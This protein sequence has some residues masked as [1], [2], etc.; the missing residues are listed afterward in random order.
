MGGEGIC[1]FGE[2]IWW[3]VCLII[4]SALGPDLS[5]VKCYQTMLGQ[6]QGQG[7]GA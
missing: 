5:K 1:K 2:G 7:Q 3:V 6:G 4:V